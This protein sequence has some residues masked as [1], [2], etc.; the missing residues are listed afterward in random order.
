MTA[1]QL[2]DHPTVAE[3]ARI[4]SN[5]GLKN[6]PFA[7]TL[8]LDMHGANWGKILAGN[9]DGNYSVVLV[10]LQVALS[11]YKNQ[12]T[13]EAEEGIVILDH[14]L[15]AKSSVE[16]SLQAEDEHRLTIIA[17][18]RGSGKS[19][20][21]TLLHSK[22]PGHFMS[23][24]PSWSGGYLNFLNKF[25]VGIGLGGQARSAGQG[26]DEILSYLSQSGG[27]I[28]IDEF[29]YFSPSA[30]NFLKSVLNA[31]QWAIAVATVPHYLSRMASD[32]Q[33]AQE[34]AQLL[35]R[36]VAIIHISPVTALHV[37]LIRNALYPHVDLGG[38]PG[39]IAAAANRNNRLDSV[40][41][42]LADA[43]DGDHIATCIARHEKMCRVTSKP[44]P[45]E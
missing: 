26:E 41:A 33:T 31:S 30:I 45:Q 3:L 5:L 36:A 43:Q 7:K 42:I 40:C 2:K 22:H 28:C 14:V 15:A 38:S 9:Y 23:A 17:G 18:P 21:L 24:L 37:D 32:R 20:T 29:N 12:G 16:L 8:R 13:G 19:R 25:S 4:Q 6:I 10:K 44:Q 34:A 11:A 1:S 27:L 35:R 39:E